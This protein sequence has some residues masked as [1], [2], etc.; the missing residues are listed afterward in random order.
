MTKTKKWRIVC[1][2]KGETP[3]D[4]AKTKQYHAI[5]SCLQ[6][7]LTT[8]NERANVCKPVGQKRTP[9]SFRSTSKT[10]AGGKKTQGSEKRSVEATGTQVHHI[11]R[12]IFFADFKD[13]EDQIRSMQ[14]KHVELS[15]VTQI[16]LN[17]EA[18]NQVCAILEELINCLSVIMECLYL[19]FCRT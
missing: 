1:H 9:E 2:Q 17:S 10:K 8:A 12:A 18:N 5:V 7:E 4:V 11:R 14:D 16:K 3:L 6:S 15:E 19:N 13:L